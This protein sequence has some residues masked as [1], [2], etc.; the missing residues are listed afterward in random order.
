MTYVPLAS[1]RIVRPCRRG[2]TL[3]E[4]VLA[5]LIGSLVVMGALGIFSLM[6]S[7]ERRTEQRAEAAINMAELHSSLQKSLSSIVVVVKPRTTAR[8]PSGQPAG[9]AAGVD[10]A[11]ASAGAAGKA[12]DADKDKGAGGDDAILSGPPRLNLVTP[13]AGLQRLEMMV[14]QPPLAVKMP[15]GFTGFGTPELG[16]GVWAAIEF[17]RDESTGFITAWWRVFREQ[18]DPAQEE[19][20]VRR[21]KGARERL[22]ERIDAR[23]G[24]QPEGEAGDDKSD[25]E[26]EQIEEEARPLVLEL[27]GERVIADGFVSVDIAFK[28]TREDPDRPGE[29]GRLMDVRNLMARTADELPAYVVVQVE[30]KDG[31]RGQWTFECVYVQSRATRP[32][33]DPTEVARRR[34]EG[35]S[36]RDR[37]GGGGGAGGGAGSSAGGGTGAAG[38]GNNPATGGSGASGGG[39]RSGGGRGRT[40]GAG[41]QGK[42]GQ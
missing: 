3:L 20:A 28:V 40:G 39:G 21:P 27:A 12:Q 13:E 5:M 8:P 9:A 38:G 2:F 42:I 15:E 7:A 23:E 1:A 14:A 26:E 19:R 18:V 37:A 6:R 32:M 16:G 22:Q 36:G 17:R 10:K 29:A 25:A 11:P 30:H 24:N 34:E 33:A 31:L 35:S 4:L 41:M